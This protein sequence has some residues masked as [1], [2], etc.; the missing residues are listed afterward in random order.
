MKVSEQVVGGGKTVGELAE[1]WASEN[2]RSE[3]LS[4]RARRS[5]PAGVTH[6]VRRADPFSVAV[7][8]AS[9]SRK[10]DLDGHEI[11]CYVLGH[12]SLLLGH[13]NSEVVAA[14][15]EQ[16][17][18]FLHPGAGHELEVDWAEAV[19]SLVPSAERVRFTSSGTEASMLALRLARA[20]TGRPKIL[21]LA[22]HFH[23]W[24]DQ[25]AFG[26]DPPFRG[27]DTAGIPPGL[28]ADVVVVPADVEAVR[29]VL[30]P[31]DV[32][33]LILEASGAAW[34]MVPL[35]AGFLAEMRRLTLET[36]TVLIFDEVVSGFRWSPGGVQQLVGVQ[37]DLTALGKILAG[38]MPG[39]AVCGRADLLGALALSAGDPRKVGH[40]GTH[41]AHPVAAAAGIVTLRLVASGEAQDAAAGLAA[42]L[43]RELTAVLDRCG[44]AGC[45]Y[46][47]SSTFHLLLGHEGEPESLPISV[48]KGGLGPRLSAELH[49]GMLLGGV[50]LF[51]GS[52]FVSTMHS[53]RDL[54]QTVEAFAATVPVLQAEGLL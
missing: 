36:G 35:P 12:G 4:V 22:G 45:A 8:R 26:T 16:A 48:L 15:Q 13:G 34:G 51:H 19:I 54:E 25:V 11:I 17:G 44:V 14:V 38:G 3:A 39:G 49:C 53:E 37:P 43:R 46:G 28:Q 18:H 24:N 10:W 7:A 40:P 33:A 47:Q 41:N 2:P 9:G 27:P 21:K 50:H 52:G 23:G 5:L 1:R 32:A 6:D 31:R 42:E 29:Q 30:A 20:T